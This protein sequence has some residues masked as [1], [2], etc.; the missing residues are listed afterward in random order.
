MCEICVLEMKPRGFGS[1]FVTDT[2][3]T[4]EA[5]IARFVQIVAAEH[6]IDRIVEIV[7][8]IKECEGGDKNS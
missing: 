7:N 6:G 5:E 4:S 8:R 2:M 3:P 1:V